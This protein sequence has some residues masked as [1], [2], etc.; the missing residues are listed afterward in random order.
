MYLFDILYKLKTH[1]NRKFAIFPNDSS[2]TQF[3]KLTHFY[4][5]RRK[6]KIVEQQ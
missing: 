3:G 4:V 1:S 6:S 5:Y 2:F